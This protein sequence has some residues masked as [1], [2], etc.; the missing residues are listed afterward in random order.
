[1]VSLILWDTLS[2]WIN[3]MGK[4]AR[5]SER[6][7]YFALIPKET[8][9]I[10]EEKYTWNGNIYLILYKR[11]VMGKVEELF[12]I[13]GLWDRLLYFFPKDKYH[14]LL[15]MILSFYLT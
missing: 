9:Q 3:I 10:L 13:E 6:S 5:G 15:F 11:T 1:M 8:E 7:K 14:L 12:I 4:D 2:C